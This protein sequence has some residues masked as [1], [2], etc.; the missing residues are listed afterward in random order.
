[1]ISPKFFAIS[2]LLACP[3]ALARVQLRTQAE[4]KNN[5]KQSNHNV[6][7]TFQIDAHES[8][9]VY[10]HDNLKVV[11]ELLAEEEATATVCFTVYA[12]NAT[13]E[14][15]KISAPVLVPN[16]TEPAT[17]AVGSSDGEIFTMHVEAQRV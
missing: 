17:I 11:A 14:Y 1:M 3:F 15:E 5:S 7:I 4:L 2:L 9:E 16:Y 6:D 10:N 12:K 13:G 8:L